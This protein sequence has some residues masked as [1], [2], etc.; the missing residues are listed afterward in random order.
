[1]GV[2]RL[3]LTPPEAA[4]R[5]WVV[6][7]MRALGLE[8]RVDRIGN[9]YARRRARRPELAPVLIG[10]HIDSVATA[11]IFDGC[12]GVLG[13]LE[14]IR[15]L[16][17]AGVETARALEVAFFSEEEGARFGTDMLG[18]AVATG[19]IPLEQAYGLVDRGGVS[20]REALEA[21][22]FL[23]AAPARL[24][25]PHAFL[26]VHIEQGPT[27]A[28]RG[29]ELGVV[30]GVQ[31]ISWREL[32][33]SGKSAHA[34]TT[35]TELRCDAGL[36][37]AQIAVEV[38]R[39]AT[40]GEFRELRGTVGVLRP[41]PGLVNVIPGGCHLT[42]DLRSPD[43][44]ALEAGEAHLAAFV[45]RAA[46]AEGVEVESRQTAR[47]ETVRFDGRLQDRITAAAERAGLRH[48]RLVSGAG[49]DAQELSSICPAAMIFVPG[50]NE[51]ISH[52]PRELSTPAQC[53][54]GVSVLLEVAL[55]LAQEE[56][57]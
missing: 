41:H 15:A 12:L 44:A 51:G 39:M 52:N 6:E 35:P 47:T 45:E 5:R 29:L 53:A 3:A 43:D 7:Q 49:H 19:R 24:E 55:E 10:S 20:V 16:D 31:A 9:V 27:L 33:L 25:P 8:V 50:E 2:R 42:V 26:E 32:Y 37:A 56:D 54:A 34:G 11:G 57:A 46:A 36:V 21:I 38:R 17:E 4:G 14:V 40:C 13:G 18:S 28:A 48:E 22:D 30:T 1:M 23:G